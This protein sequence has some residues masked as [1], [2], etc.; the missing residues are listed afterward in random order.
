MAVEHKSLKDLETQ[1]LLVKSKND[2]SEDCKSVYTVFLPIIE[3]DFRVVLQGNQTDCLDVC[4]ESGDPALDKFEGS[5]LVFVATGSNPFDLITNAVKYC[6]YGGAPKGL[7][8]KELDRGADIVVATPGRLN[9]IL[10]MKKIDFRQISLL[11]LDEADRMLDMGFEP[12]IRKI[13]N[14]IPARRQTLMYTAIWPKEVRKIAGDLLV[15]PV[16]VNIGKVDELAANKSIT[17]YVEVVPQMEKQRRLEKI[18]MSQERGSKII[19]FCSTKKM[20]DQLTRTISRT[21]GA[22]AIH[23][24]KSQSNR[25]YVLNKFQSGDCPILVATDV[26]ARGLD[27]KDISMF[28]VN[29]LHLMFLLLAAMLCWKLIIPDMLNWFGVKPGVV[30]M[31]HYE[32][33][34][35]F[36]VSSPGVESD[37]LC[38]ALTCMT[39]NGLGLVNPDKVFSFYDE[40]HS[41]SV[42]PM[43]EYHGAARAVGGCG[44][45]VS[46]KPGHHNFNLLK[47]LVLPN[48]S[49]LRAK[50]PG[51]PTCLT[52]EEQSKN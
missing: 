15:N 16:Q 18:L 45:Y 50:L 24:E 12:Q 46:D 14:E 8:L 51:R 25:D 41:Y 38:G 35:A 34:L 36:P 7:Q 13:V 44:I 23:G 30:E 10:E 39:K 52:L 19:I 40:L 49:I 6:L 9:D 3:G 27:I 22:A 29:Y 42:H 48:G 21:F 28:F 33:K 37:E 43:A 31:E 32:S 26:A 20:C 2:G 11:V 1:F 17:Q 4:L 5:H 47:K